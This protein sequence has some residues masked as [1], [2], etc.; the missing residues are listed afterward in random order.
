MWACG[1]DQ[2]DALSLRAGAAL[3]GMDADELWQAC[4]AISGEVLAFASVRDAILDSEDLDVRTWNVLAR[5]INV[6][7]GEH[8]LAPLFR[9]R[10]M[11]DPG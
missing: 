3:A 7:L 11:A 4:Y 2:T 6:R 1:D 10:S 5:A 9:I 8:G